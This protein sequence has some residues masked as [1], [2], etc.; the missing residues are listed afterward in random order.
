MQ[1]RR[2]V[3]LLSGVVHVTQ[4]GTLLKRPPSK[5]SSPL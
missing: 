1:L 3:A 4:W 2:R 5:L